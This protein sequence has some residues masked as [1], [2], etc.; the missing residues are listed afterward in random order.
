MPQANSI[1]T[2]RNRQRDSLDA[3][4]IRLNDREAAFNKQLDMLPDIYPNVPGSKL[5]GLSTSPEREVIMKGLKQISENRE[6]IP[7]MQ[8]MIEQP[9][10]S[11]GP[12]DQL[13]AQVDSLKKSL[14]EFISMKPKESNGNGAV[15]V[16]TQAQGGKVTKG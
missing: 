5:S 14:A 4:I 2:Y 16:S 11:G 3:H 15:P 12:I 7:G 9:R 6:K 13:Q 10:Q 8:T 1:N